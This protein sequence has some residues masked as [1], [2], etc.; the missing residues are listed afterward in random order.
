MLRQL[1][2]LHRPRDVRLCSV[3]VGELYHGAHKSSRKEQDLSLVD[4]LVRVFDSYSFDEAAAEAFGELR[5]FLE[6]KGTRL[7]LMIYRSQPLSWLIA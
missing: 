7:A 5:A 2:V 6:S 4:E 3:V 1:V